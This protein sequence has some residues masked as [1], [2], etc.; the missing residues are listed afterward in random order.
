MSADKEARRE[1]DIHHALIFVDMLGFGELT[2]RNPHRISDRQ[3]ER[4]QIVSST[5][6]LQTQ[7]VRFQRVIDNLIGNGSAGRL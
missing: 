4:G 2:R 3:A 7:L 6:R 1:E 5:S